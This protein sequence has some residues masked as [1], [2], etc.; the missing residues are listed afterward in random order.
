V[1]HDGTP[2]PMA[3][4]MLLALAGSALAIRFL[5]LPRRQATA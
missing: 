3:L 4:V 5:A 1:L 2:R